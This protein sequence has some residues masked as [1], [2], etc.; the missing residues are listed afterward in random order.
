MIMSTDPVKKIRIPKVNLDDVRRAHYDASNCFQRVT[1]K[2]KTKGLALRYSVCDLG[3]NLPDKVKRRGKDGK[4]REVRNPAKIHPEW[5]VLT[6]NGRRFLSIHS[7]HRTL[8][9]AERSFRQLAATLGDEDPTEDL[10][11]AQAT[12]VDRVDRAGTRGVVV[13]NGRAKVAQTM[14]KLGLIALETIEGTTMARTLKKAPE[15]KADGTKVRAEYH[16][17]APKGTMTLLDAAAKVL[18]GLPGESLHVKVLVKEAATRGW[19]VSTAK[20]PH[21]TLGSAIGTEIRKKGDKAR[22]VK[23]APGTFRHK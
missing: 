20:T 4:V 13:T 14:E 6:R 9:A 23:T 8:E 1:W 17:Q 3:S 16:A 18:A 5:L 2:H 12:F 22:F 11:D 10:T 15:V 21:A 19:H 7:R